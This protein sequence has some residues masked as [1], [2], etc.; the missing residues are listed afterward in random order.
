MATEQFERR[1]AAIVAADVVGYSRLMEADEAGTL[2]RLTAL[3]H[4]LVEPKIADYHG[5]IVK[6]MGD[7]ILAEFKSVVDALAC[8]VDIQRALQGINEDVIEEQRIT[9]RIGINLGDVIVQDDD[10][11]GDGVNVAARLETLAEPGGICLSGTAFDHVRNKLDIDIEALG[12]RSVKNIAQPVRVYRVLFSDSVA[13]QKKDPHPPRL[14]LW[15]TV[16]VAVAIVSLGLVF[17][18]GLVR[19]QIAQPEAQTI[20]SLVVLPFRNLSDDR[21]QDYFVD[22]VTEDL[23]TDLSQLDGLFVIARNT[24]FAY[25]DRPVT[26]LAEEL[27]IRYALEGS[28]RRQGSRIRVS[29]QLID[30]ATN[31]QL[32]GESYDRE[33]TDVFAVQDDL[34]QQ[35]VAA[36]SVQLGADQEAVLSSRPIENIEAYDFYLRARNARYQGDLRSLRLAYWTAEKAI[37]LEP[38]FAKA[39]ALLADLYALDYMGNIIPLDWE[40][41]PL[42]AKSAAEHFA[43]RAQAVDS[44]IATPDIA[45]A[46]LRLAELRFQDALIH[47]QQAVELEPGLSDTHVILAQTLSALGRHQEAL[48]AVAEAFRLNPEAPTEQ[49]AV[50][51][52]ALFGLSDYEAAL[53]S[54]KAARAVAIVSLNWQNT[55]LAVAAAGFAG[56]TWTVSGNRSIL[57]SMAPFDAVQTIVGFPIFAAPED[58]SR[59]VEGLRLAGVPEYRGDV[60]SQTVQSLD[61]SA[62]E[63]LLFGREATSFCHTVEYS[64]ALQISKQGEALWKLRHN[65]SETGQARVED[66]RLCLRF[67]VIGRDRDLCFRIYPNDPPAIN[68]KGHT[69]VMDG[70]LLCFFTPG[71]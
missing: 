59:L 33:M 31:R 11:Y 44:S 16:A 21:S 23:I 14:R 63:A 66:G 49:H 46:H 32:W 13:P 2:S 67:P 39:L 53:E 43:R 7:G 1:L 3:R 12:E 70:P 24:A 50:Q 45:L 25:R 22:G 64:P 19:H 28:L 69:Y 62:I 56:T 8:A 6:L 20:P 17:A 37:E 48:M 15:L 34:K 9:L 10:I 65:I 54:F 55:A 47:A 61:D 42:I 26:E 71:S 57:G 51:G 68:S 18:P 29:A 40:R 41:S 5:R 4:E 35:I 60:V 38:D 58:Q 36:L 30:A 52:M 27:N